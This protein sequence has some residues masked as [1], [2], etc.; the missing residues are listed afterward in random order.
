MSA[1]AVLAL[2]PQF[3]PFFELFL[4]KVKKSPLPRL[5]PNFAPIF[6]RDVTNMPGPYSFGARG[7]SPRPGFDLSREKIRVPGVGASFW[8]LGSLVGHLRLWSGWSRSA[9]LSS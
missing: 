9:P 3:F 7:F 2:P 1:A 8:G 5:E 4:E 6:P